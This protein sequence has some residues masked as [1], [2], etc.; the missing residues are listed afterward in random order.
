MLMIDKLLLL[1]LLFIQ[2]PG[3]VLGSSQSDSSL[4]HYHGWFAS[5]NLLV[6]MALISISVSK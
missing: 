3:V 4:Y 2:H 6:F 5:V 1:L